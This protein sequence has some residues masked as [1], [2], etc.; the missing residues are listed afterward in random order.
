VLS[1]ACH[2]ISPLYYFFIS[3]YIIIEGLEGAGPFSIS[4]YM[5]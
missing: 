4:E 5:F 3:L 1:K 2:Y